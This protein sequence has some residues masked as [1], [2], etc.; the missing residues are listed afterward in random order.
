M[1]CPKCSYISFDH[2]ASCSK[3]GNDLS[4]LVTLLHGTA[5]EV[6]TPF[7]LGPAVGALGGD[8]Q[9]GELA[10]DDAPEIEQVM[11]EAVDFQLE[12]DFETDADIDLA[13]MDG[14]EAVDFN[15]DDDV[16]FAA[17]AAGEV[18]ETVGSQSDV[19]SVD[20]EMEAVVDF[21]D[22]PEEEMVAEVSV[23]EEQNET[24]TDVT[25]DV[26]PDPDDIE[27]DS[28]VEK[29]SAV[30]LEDSLDDA[31]ADLDDLGFD[32]LDLPEI[33][34]EPDA[35]SSG[36]R[37]AGQPADDDDITA[38][39]LDEMF[40]GL[41]FDEEEEVE[42]PPAAIKEEAPSRKL[43]EIGELTLQM[44]DSDTAPGSSSGFSDLDLS[45]EI[46]DE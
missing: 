12:P 1:R 4:E 3:C 5:I 8:D 7:F 18:E 38:A 16:E 39:E 27:E 11:E 22:L 14:E 2:L 13:E 17:V 36:E 35:Y 6:E 37:S 32:D 28:F 34:E 40:A 23:E 29:E 45:L 20:V 19:E 24:M 44:D 42:A 15:L 30:D 43:P 46:E 41:D 21:E 33:E 31:L 25:V 26:T 9:F 10:I